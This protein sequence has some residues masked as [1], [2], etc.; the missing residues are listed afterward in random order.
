[1][2]PFTI[3]D[4]IDGIMSKKIIIISTTLLILTLLTS[5]NRRIGSGVVLWSND[6]SPIESGT[7]VQIFEESKIRQTYSIAPVGSK[8]KIEM[9]Q[10]RIQFYD[11]MQDAED[12]AEAYSPYFKSFAYSDRQGL[13]IREAETTDS[14]R[15]YKLKEGQVIKV[16][17]RADDEVQ[18][19]NLRPGY[20]YHVLTDDGVDGYVFDAVLTVFSMNDKGRVIENARETLDPLLD[21]FLDSVWRPSYFNDMITKDI[22]DLSSFKDIYALKI[23]KDKKEIT[24][25]LHDKNVTETYTEITQFGSKRYDFAETSFRVTL[26]SEYVASVLYQFEGKDVNEAFV[27]LDE[28]VGEIVSEEL[29]RRDALLVELIERGKIF[30]SANY[31][32]INIIDGTGRFI[33][34]DIERLIDRNIIS[35]SSEPQG[36]IEFNHFPDTLIKNI[37]SGVITFNFFKGSQANF[38]YSYTETGVSFIFVPDRYIKNLIVTTDQ[39]FDPIQIYFEFDPSSGSKNP[40]NDEETE[41]DT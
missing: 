12:Y 26:V 16:I 39:F 22:I 24:L 5:C 27:R 18:V 15:V 13:P 31:G 30:E 28:N 6:D 32:S 3:N 19:G 7:I 40:E 23:D 36:K 14:D 35:S 20:W 37:Y 17:G 11:K 29:A 33:W 8:E 9:E 25:R 38:L 34:N 10:W 2:P 1:L 41:E 21:N 4:K